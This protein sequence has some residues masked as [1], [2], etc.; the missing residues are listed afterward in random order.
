MIHI[1]STRTF[2]TMV[3]GVAVASAILGA[4]ADRALLARQDGVKR[5]V[6]VRADDPAGPG[7]E[8]V[9]ALAEL[10]P[11]SSIGKHRHSG[12]ELAYL[13]EGTVV[14]EQDGQAAV[15][16]KPGEAR[17]N[18][19]AHDARNA[20]STP[21]KILAVYLVEKGKPLAEPVK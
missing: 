4:G 19:G 5:T 11:G 13:I 20:G 16:L 15:T 9:M 6:L 12:I 7:Y 17:R 1:P 8:A 14:V 21:A 3:I 2:S 10:A 18:V